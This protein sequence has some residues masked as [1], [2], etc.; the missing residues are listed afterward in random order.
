MSDSGGGRARAVPAFWTFDFKIPLRL[1]RSVLF[2]LNSISASID[3]A[4]SAKAAL[5]LVR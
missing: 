5:L 3:H 4:C 2:A 1:D